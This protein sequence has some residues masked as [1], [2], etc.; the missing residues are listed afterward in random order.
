MPRLDQIIMFESQTVAILHYFTVEGGENNQDPVLPLDTVEEKNGNDGDNE[1]SHETCDMVDCGTQVD[2]DFEERFVASILKSDKKL[3]S[4]TG[5]HNVLLLNSLTKNFD[6]IAPESLHKKFTL[7][8]RDRIILTMMKIKLAVSFSALAALFD[9][10]VQT[11]SYYFYDTV[12]ILAKILGPAVKWPDKEA[13]LKNLPKSFDNFTSTRA[14]LDAFEI[15]IEKP[16][17]IKCRVRSWSQYK[18]KQ[19]AKALMI[20]TPSGLISK[21]CLVFGGRASDKVVTQNSGIYDLCDPVTDSLMVD[22]G[23]NID[24]ECQNH[25]IKLIRPPFMRQNKNFSK[26]ESVQCAK[27]ARARVHVE[28]V[29]Q[30]VRQ[31]H[32]LKNPVPWT[33]V[34]CLDDLIVIVSALVNLGPPIMSTDKY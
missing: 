20:C 9:L 10:S 11:C 31:Y 21:T 13:I 6:R 24:E 1:I 15:A 26:A 3:F 27:I 12:S 17:C 34:P 25:L 7:C 33:I 18:G 29:I 5:L 30:R 8:T 19:T 16:K 22:K 32:I 28:R 23:F 14:I 4:A 2:F